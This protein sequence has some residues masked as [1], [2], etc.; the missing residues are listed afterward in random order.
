[1]NV[2]NC[3][4]LYYWILYQKHIT[5]FW[6]CID[7]V[8]PDIIYCILSL[9]LYV[10]F[11]NQEFW[12]IKNSFH[13][14]DVI[15]FNVLKVFKFWRWNKEC[16]NKKLMKFLCKF[17]IHKRLSLLFVVGS[18]FYIERSFNLYSPQMHLYWMVGFFFT[19]VDCKILKLFVFLRCKNRFY[20]L[21]LHI[22]TTKP[23][24]SSGVP[25][26]TYIRKT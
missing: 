16:F 14:F 17:F 12:I 10:Y 1:M 11:L 25:L 24:F 20:L 2:E 22:F 7:F 4:N 13:H 21:F 3:S 5:I 8:S 23:S 18:I 26:T 9:N 19:Q 15:S 6:L